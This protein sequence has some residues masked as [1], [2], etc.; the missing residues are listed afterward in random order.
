MRYLSQFPNFKLGVRPQRMRPVGDGGVEITQEALAAEFVPVTDGG[1]I[2]E[3]EEVAA[4]KHFD[5]RGQTQQVDEATPT[6]PLLRLSVF[7]LDEAA[8]QNNWDAATKAEVGAKLDYWAENSQQQVLKVASKPIAAPFPN[9]DVYERP[10]EQLIVKLVED[11]HDLAQ[12]LYYEQ[13]YGPNRPEV[14]E[15]LEISVEN[16]KA[17]T[18][19]A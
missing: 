13:S 19:S 1:Q 18:I 12:V 2:F 3:S 5:F 14:V 16:M 15:A 6:D 11:G 10:V 8:Q 4:L 7:D 9:Y 17:E